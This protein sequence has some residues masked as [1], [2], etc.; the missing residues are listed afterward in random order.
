MRQILIN[1]DG[2]QQTKSSLPTPQALQWT[3]QQQ[4]SPEMTFK[5]TSGQTRHSFCLLQVMANVMT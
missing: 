3:V 4:S 1:M 5:K 2:D